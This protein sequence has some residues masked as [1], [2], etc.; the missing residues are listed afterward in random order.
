MALRLRKLRNGAVPE[1]N[2][3]AYFCKAAQEMKIAGLDPDAIQA[4]GRTTSKRGTRRSRTGGRI[5]W[6]LKHLS[7]E[8]TRERAKRSEEFLHRKPVVFTAEGSR[9]GH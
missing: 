8:E 6:D 7:E 3:R 9:K 2:G 1:L 5:A 4:L